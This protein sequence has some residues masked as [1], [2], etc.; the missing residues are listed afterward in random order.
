M[1]G[2]ANLF[3]QW[4]IHPMYTKVSPYIE[5]KAVVMKGLKYG[6]IDCEGNVILAPEYEKLT[7]FKYGKIW[8]MKNGLWGMLNDKGATLIDFQYS[9]INPIAFT[10]LS[11]V[12]KGEVWGLVNEEKGNFICKPQF[13]IA[14]VMSENATLVQVNPP[15]FGVINHVDCGYLIPH[16]ITKVKKVGLHTFIYEQNNKWGV[17][18][19]WGKVVSNAMYD[20]L[21]AVKTA[22][23]PTQKNYDY[24]LLTLKDKQFGLM[25]MAGKELLP[26][27]FEEISEF[28]D[29]FF[30]VKQKGKYGYANRIGKVY[31][32]PQYEQ[33]DLFFNG[34]AIVK[35][36]G[37]Y[38]VINAKNQFVFP[39]KYSY[40]TRNPEYK[41]FVVNEKDNSGNDRSFFYGP[42]GKKLSNEAFDSVTVTDSAAFMRVRKD[43]KV[44]FYNTKINSYS[45]EGSFDKAEPFENEYAFVQNGG[46]WGMID[47]KGKLLVPFNY[48]KIEFERFNQKLVVK[49]LLNGKV[50][51]MD[52][53]GGKVTTVLTN[54]YD[55]VI[56]APPIFL[57]VKKHDK[58]AIYKNSGEAITD[59]VYDFISNEQ[60]TPGIPEWPAIMVKKG[61]YGLVN[62]KGEEIF[63][64]NAQKIEFVGEMFYAVKEKKDWLVI[65]SKGAQIGSGKFD[66]VREYNEGLAAVRKGNK[67]G[68]I[69]R[70]GTEK[71]KP[72][73]D[74]AGMFINYLA[75]VQ[76]DGLWGVIDVNGKEL[77]K[78]EYEKYIT[79]P[80]GTRTFYKGGKEYTLMKGGVMR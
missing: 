53:S 46:K 61:K 79:L 7:N 12:K 18:N 35:K 29:G 50:G 69:D 26:N 55:Q 37:K 59:F 65:N 63:D 44:R 19:E 41:F 66:E 21:A 27:Q 80:D 15:M 62:N 57:K 16:T 78:P 76:V 5:S 13:K 72:R 23:D 74:D 70:N 52:V 75:P 67:W 56:P 3:G 47:H 8:A 25:N 51:I 1:W 10:E 49:T 28:S 64:A 43:G 32:K 11:W 33:A 34:Q 38:G 9:Q 58:Y 17:F 14:Q 54:D 30:R 36:D 20:S 40:I 39:A 68:Y 24:I 2:Y 6:V 48:D 73:F 4:V 60:E 71:V 42:T 77:V 45:F 31:I 22:Y